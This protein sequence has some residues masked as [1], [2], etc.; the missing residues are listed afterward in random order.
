MHTEP[1]FT[2]TERSERKKRGFAMVFAIFIM[3]FSNG[4]FFLLT[5]G[6]GRQL[7]ENARWIY[8]LLLNVALNIGFYHEYVWNYLEKLF[9]SEGRKALKLIIAGLGTNMMMLPTHVLFWGHDTK[10]LVLN[11]VIM[12]IFFPIFLVFLYKKA[13]PKMEERIL[14]ITSKRKNN[15]EEN[16]QDP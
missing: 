9:S 16:R 15:L 8:P 6:P 3:S 2:H 11:I 14:R 12:F 7:S 10:F 5:I 4:L 1:S 13:M